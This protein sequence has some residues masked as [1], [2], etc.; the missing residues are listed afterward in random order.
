MESAK[1]YYLK[2]IN[3]KFSLNYYLSTIDFAPG[4]VEV[5]VGESAALSPHFEENFMTSETGILLQHAISKAYRSKGAAAAN[6]GNVELNGS[7]ITFDVKG[8]AP[9]SAIDTLL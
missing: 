3:D 9:D 6:I 8:V 1:D 2:A 7:L 5:N 4:R